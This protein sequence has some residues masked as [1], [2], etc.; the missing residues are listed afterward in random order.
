M[1]TIVVFGLDVI[2]S[3]GDPVVAVRKPDVFENE[4]TRELVYRERKGLGKLIVLPTGLAHVC[5][6]D[7]L[8]KHNA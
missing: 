2:Q 6:P 1:I 5:S 4:K 3:L 7:I 8:Y